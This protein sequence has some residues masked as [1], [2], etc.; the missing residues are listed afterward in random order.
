M[1]YEMHMHRPFG[2]HARGEPGEYVA[3]TERRGLAGIVVTWHNPRN[4]GRS[5]NV[6]MSLAQFDQYE[7]MVE[8]ALDILSCVG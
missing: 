5:S 1:L 8:N 7:A 2:K 4:D 3:F 6:R